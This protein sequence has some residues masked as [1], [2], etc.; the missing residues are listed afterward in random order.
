MNNNVYEL[1]KEFF[2]EKLKVENL[3]LDTPLRDYGDFDSLLV[4]ELI[5]FLEESLNIEIPEEF[6]GMENF[7][8]VAKIINLV[9]HSMN[10]KTA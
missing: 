8:T 3:E 10:C 1:L 7:E 6:Y 2:N 5:L 4:V 9:E